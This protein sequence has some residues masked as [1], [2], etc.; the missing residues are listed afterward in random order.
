MPAARSA[1]PTRVVPANRSAAETTPVLRA[2]SASDGA[3]SRFEPRYLITAA[4]L[5]GGAA[6]PIS[7]LQVCE[8]GQ[9]AAVIFGCLGQSQLLE[10]AGD[11]FFDGAFGHHHPLRDAGIGAALGHQLQHLALTRRQL[12]QRIIA[13]VASHQLTDNRRIQRATTLPHPPHRSGELVDIRHTILQQVADTL[14]RLRQQLHRIPRLHVLAQHQHPHL[15]IPLTDPLRRTQPLI[16]MRRRHPDIHDRHIRLRKPHPPHQ[17]LRII[18]LANYLKPRIHQQP[19]HTLPQQHR[20]IR[21]HYPHGITADTQVPAPLLC[22]AS[23]PSRASTRSASP[24][25]PVPPSGSAPPT[26]SSETSIVALPSERMI[27]TVACLALA[28][29]ATFVSAS[30]TT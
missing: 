13:A 7:S 26:P 23:V 20:I 25:R 30:A 29:L 5:R 10:D 4:T 12:R 1:W 15:R 8:Y 3:S 21:E 24:R 28:Y 14:T 22:T 19:R 9:D 16:R 18:N 6:S 17:I 11:V 2:I 27:R